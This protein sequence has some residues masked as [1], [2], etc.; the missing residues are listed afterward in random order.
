MS[1][2]TAVE[3][4]LEQEGDYSDDPN[5]PGKATN[6]GISSAAYPDIDVKKLTREDAI[7][8]Y[9]KDYWD[10]CKCGELPEGLATVLFDS[11]VNQGA[12][13][14]IR[15]LQQGLGVTADGVIGPVTIEASW[16]KP[17]IVAEMVARR[18][19]SYGSIPQFTRYG[20]G[21]SRRLAKCHALAM[22]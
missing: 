6:F 11:A 13:S 18:M 2:E 10:R 9:R 20:L 7:G 1:F 16:K 12:T 15:M 19:V 17:G 5:D 8:L 4:V 14:A 3:F 21:W 22:E